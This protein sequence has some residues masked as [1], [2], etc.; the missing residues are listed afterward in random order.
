[1]G[2]PC[3]A[4]QISP[5]CIEGSFRD[6]AKV[7]E[8]AA[9]SDIITTEIEHVDI[10]SLGELETRGV[11]VQPS[12][13]TIR[14]IQDKYLQKQYLVT[15]QVAVADFVDISTTESVREAGLRFGYPFLLKRR[16]LSYDGRGNAIVSSESGIEE[17][18]EK[19]G[20]C[21]TDLYAEEM[22]NFSKEL[23][24]MVVKGKHGLEA[25][26]VVETIQKDNICHVVV[27]PAQVS[28][29]V[30]KI[31]IDLALKSVALFNG[32][33]VYGV[34]MFLLH[35]DTILVNEIAPR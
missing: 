35:D 24:V 7:L 22:V 18:I 10:Q 2:S 12:A 21:A 30:K 5:L 31:A 16:K 20:G 13:S 9:I 32:L 25:F 14:I 11:V 6:S 1:M 4:G 23:A 19:L 27:A 33:G 3:P 17:A 29:M 8:L 26:P 34:E 15:H 28:S